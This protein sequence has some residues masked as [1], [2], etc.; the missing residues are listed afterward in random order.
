MEK[1]YNVSHGTITLWCRKFKNKCKN[2]EGLQENYDY[3]KEILKLNTELENVNMR[4]LF[5]KKNSQTLGTGDK[6]MIYEC[7]EENKNEYG[8][9]WLLKVCKINKNSDLSFS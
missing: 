9:N 3:R 8:L 7:I 4:K 6:R 1:E 2:D 5:F